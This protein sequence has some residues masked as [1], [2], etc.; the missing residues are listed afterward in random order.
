MP[1]SFG[2]STPTDDGS[3]L[4]SRPRALFKGR[5]PEFTMAT[6]RERITTYLEDNDLQT[7]RQGI[8]LPKFAN[9]I[10]NLGGK[11]DSK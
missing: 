1:T 10:V 7:K 2:F 11:E 3:P 6:Y 9:K 5:F 4:L 8:K